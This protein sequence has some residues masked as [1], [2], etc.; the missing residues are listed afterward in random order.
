[1]VRNTRVNPPRDPHEEQLYMPILPNRKHNHESKQEHKTQNFI[2]RFGYTTKVSYSPL[3]SPQRAGSFPTLILHNPTTKVKGNRFSNLLTR[4]G[5][6]NFLG[7]S[8]TLETPK[9]PQSLRNSKVTRTTSSH[10]RCLQQAQEMRKRRE[11]KTKSKGHTHK[12]HTK[13]APSVD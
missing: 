11:R 7:S 3:R 2:P 1:M 5:D 13:G 6:T 8:T 4:A 12:P 9:Q 10:K